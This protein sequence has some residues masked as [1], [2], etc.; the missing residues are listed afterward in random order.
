MRNLFV[1]LLLI[2]ASA[3]ALPAFAE[4]PEGKKGD[5]PGREQMRERMIKEFDKDGDGKLSEDERAKM[6]EQMR[7]RMGD[8]RPGGPGGERGP[9][10][11]GFRGRGPGGPG[12]PPYGPPHRPMPSPDELFKKF[13]ADNSDSL[14]REEF[15]KL[16]EFVKEHHPPGPPPGGP[17]GE[18][19][20][21]RGPGGFEGRGPGRPD[22][23][24]R[25]GER[26]RRDRGDQPK[27][28][29]ADKADKNDADDSI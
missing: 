11:E 7:Q 9:R 5:R 12:G 3:A 29:K 25:D 17:R 4:P 23:P 20:R 27:G 15:G 24:P 22:G 26:R 2:G 18:G 13:D 8:R 10:G 21:G 14:S 1:L 28:D 19:F 6:R 16:A